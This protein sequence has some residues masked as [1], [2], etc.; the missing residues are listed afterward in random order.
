MDT[1]TNIDIAPDADLAPAPSIEANKEQ[2]REG[3][4]QRQLEKLQRENAE[5]KRRAEEQRKSELTE[6]QKLREEVDAIKSERE[7][8]RVENLRRKVAAEYK[9][10]DAFV[11]RLMGDDEDSLRADAESLA[12]MLPR[13]KV[14][15]PTDP[16]RDVVQGKIY[17]REEL[18]LNPTLARSPEVLQAMVEGRIR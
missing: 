1:E 17:T 16:V 8:L 15:T 18:R 9:L 5:L 13:P 3:Y 7:S 4:A 14:G 2:N 12:S 10:P 11:N 6:Y